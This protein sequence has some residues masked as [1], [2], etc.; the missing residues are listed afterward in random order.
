MDIQN[1]TEKYVPWVLFIITVCAFIIRALYFN[2]NPPA[3]N[4][5]EAMNGY[6]AFSLSSNFRDSWGFFFPSL[7]HGFGNVDYRSPLYAYMS[8]PFVKILGLSETSTRMAA[9]VFNTAL[10]PLT[11]VLARKLRFDKFTSIASAAFLALCPWS[12]HYSRIGH[13]AVLSPFFYIILIILLHNVLSDKQCDM[14]CD[15]HCDMQCDMHCDKQRRWGTY[16]LIGIIFGISVYSY[17]VARM[18]SPLIVAFMCLVYFNSALKKFFRLLISGLI[19][20]IIIFPM[21]YSSIINPGNLESRFGQVSIFSSPGILRS[22]ITNYISHF[23]PGFLFISGDN[24][25]LPASDGSFGMLGIYLAPLLIF[26]VF[27]LVRSIIVNKNG[28]KEAI[29]TAGFLFLYPLPSAL[30]FP[31]PHALRAYT[32]IPVIC[33]VAAL[34]L[35]Q[36]YVWLSELRAGRIIMPAVMSVIIILTV[37]ASGTFLVKYYKHFPIETEEY[38]QYGTKQA[39]QYLNKHQDNYDHIYITD[40]INQPFIYVLFYTSYDPA[41]YQQI[42][43][44][45][46]MSSFGFVSSFDKYRFMSDNRMPLNEDNSLYITEGHTVLKGRVLVETISDS[47]SNAIFRIWN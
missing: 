7:M 16:V 25:N 30:T 2:S 33:I 38:Y 14:Q 35:K 6:N 34:G 22:F 41:K 44:D 15:M 32:L 39:M 4:Q 20:F 3:L 9:L 37:V 1:K 45:A 12:I 47:K 24:G 42:K 13:E 10:V 21:I 8:I 36:L 43:K 11:Y 23:S 40:A 29:L 46:D 5:D 31:A 19:G 26:G 28:R 17:Q 18:M 27:S